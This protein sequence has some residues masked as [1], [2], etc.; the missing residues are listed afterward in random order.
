[1]SDETFLRLS[2]V[3]KRFG[4]LAALDGIDLD[5]RRGEFMSLLGQSGCGKT[6]TL[7]LVAGFDRPTSGSILLDGRRIDLDPPFRR[8]VNTVFQSYALFPHMTVGENVGFGLRFDGAGKRERRRRADEMLG[9][10]GLADKFDSSPG[11]LS[12]GQMQR[13]AL[14]RALIKNPSVLLLDEPLSALDAK[15]RRELQLELKRTQRETGVTFIY[16]THDQEEE[17]VMSDRITVMDAGRICQT[18]TPE[19]VFRAPGSRFVAEFVGQSNKLNGQVD[20]HDGTAVRVRLDSGEVVRLEPSRPSRLAPGTRVRVVLRPKD[21]RV[22]GSEDG[23]VAG[24]VRDVIFLGDLR[25]LVIALADGTEVEITEP[26][27]DPEPRTP[28]QALPIAIAE[29]P[30]HVFEAADG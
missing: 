2:G 6:T 20:G 5:V 10:M 28:G 16:V 3:V 17:M 29:T 21:I 25:K 24:N 23:Q 8:P 26:A 11:T 7:R 12:G 14:A 4:D 9:R 22:A 15:L 13:V 30:V 1:M 19:E 27:D 18:A